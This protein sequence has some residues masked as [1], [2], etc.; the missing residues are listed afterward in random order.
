MPHIFT[1]CL[2]AYPE[3][4]NRDGKMLYDPDCINVTEF[5]NLLNELYANG[6]SLV[7]IHDIYQ[8]DENG[9]L[10]MKEAV[11]VPKGRKPVV[12]SI[13]DVVYD[14]DKRGCGMVDLLTLDEQGNLVSGT[15]LPD[16]T[17]E[18]SYDR[19]VFPILE[20]FIAEHPDFSSHGARV[21]LCMTGFAGV[22]GFRTE[23]SD[24]PGDRQ[25]EI[26]KATAVANRL[27]ELGYTFA[28]H[29]YGHY[30]HEKHSVSSLRA[31]LQA[32]QDEV[33]PII[34]EVSVYVYPYGK[35][36]YPSDARYK[37][38]QEFGFDLFCSVSHF[39][40]SRDYE[41]G[42]TLYMTRVAIDGYS[43]RNYKTVLSPLFD[44]EKVIDHANRP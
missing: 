31:D 25:A 8:E 21:T 32:F 43:L 26:E 28:S 24:W 14:Y 9:V 42:D 30:N 2:I 20:T 4:K 19:D 38:M 33:V 10:T 16:G 17:I 11:E 13:D 7:D 15:Y 12:F 23:E 29:S 5:K 37:V 39:F 40:F 36:L 22:F 3:L 35:L 18:Y 6:Y 1:H 41:S 27:K 44:T 34:G